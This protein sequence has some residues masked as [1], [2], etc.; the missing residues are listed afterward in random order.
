V[1]YRKL[2][3]FKA[4]LGLIEGLGEGRGR[5]RERTWRT[6]VAHREAGEIRCVSLL[7]F[8]AAFGTSEEDLVVIR[9]VVSQLSGACILRVEG[10]QGRRVC[11]GVSDERRTGAGA[12]ST[13][14]I[15]PSPAT[16][17]CYNGWMRAQTRQED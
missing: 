4:N 8:P 13:M 2:L 16:H 14:S 17:Q 6:T 10:E 1:T 3:K 11:P 12:V 9:G 15:G 5:G 7:F